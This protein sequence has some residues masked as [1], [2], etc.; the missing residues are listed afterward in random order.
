MGRAQQEAENFK[1][2]KYQLKDAV[3]LDFP[4]YIKEIL[5]EIIGMEYS[6]FVCSVPATLCKTERDLENRN[7][8]KYTSIIVECPTAAIDLLY[9]FGTNGCLHLVI[10]AQVAESF[11]R[12]ALEDSKF[13]HLTAGQ[14][15]Q[16][17]N[18]KP[19]TEEG[20]HRAVGWPPRPLACYRGRL[21][22]SEKV[23]AF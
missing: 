3:L 10:L 18:P 12:I 15:S 4:E 16:I 23:P 1:D 13:A 8:N 5:K 7:L 17:S 9:A 20:I 2:K 6:E 19:P 14:G 21:V 22:S 11:K